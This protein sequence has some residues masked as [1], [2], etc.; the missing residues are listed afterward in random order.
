MPIN[1]SFGTYVN[2][3]KRDSLKELKLVEKLLKNH[4][5]R[6]ENYLEN[7]DGDDPYIFCYNPLKQGSFEGVRIYKIANMIA[8]RVQKES[9]THPY[10]RAYHLPIEEMFDD[11]LEDENTS[12]EKAGK[13]V[14]EAVVKEVRRFFE[15]S[16]EIEKDD[17]MSSI[18]GEPGEGMGNVAIRQTGTDYGSMIHN[19]T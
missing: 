14:I 2:K 4:G 13:K 15:K 6:V 18:E 9:K 8:F 19:K 5:L 12:E 1:K 7:S 16:V 3:R 11:F 17:R 10:G